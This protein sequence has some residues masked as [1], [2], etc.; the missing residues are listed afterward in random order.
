VAS[1]FAGRA[2]V[3][4]LA[5]AFGGSEPVAR[6]GVVVGYPRLDGHSREQRQP[7][8]CAQRQGTLA[9]F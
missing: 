6:P 1:A 2:P 9:S 5:H 7:Q 4:R 8:H 3:E